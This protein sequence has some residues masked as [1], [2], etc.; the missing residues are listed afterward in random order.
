MTPI[1]TGVVASGISGHLTPPWAPEG[2]FDALAS[3][4]VGSGGTD[5]IE[6]FGIPGNYKHLQ[7]R[8][9]FLTTANGGSP[10]V[11]FNGDTSSNY[12]NHLIY[13]SGTSAATGYN[14]SNTGMYIGGS[15]TGTNSTYPMVGIIDVL[16]YNS[17]S[18]NKTIKTLSGLDSNGNGEISLYSG[19]WYNSSSPVSYVKIYAPSRTISEYSSFALYGVK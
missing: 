2:A 17:T 7:I 9:S 1:L 8:F 15:N 18:K 6:F 12:S 14:V 4:T 10:L 13:G 16:D 11:R 3:V 5:S 19:A